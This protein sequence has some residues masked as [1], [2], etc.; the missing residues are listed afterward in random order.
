MMFH[1]GTLFLL[2]FVSYCITTLS[3][4]KVRIQE[5]RMK[6]VRVV[7]NSNIELTEPETAR[8]CLRL[9]NRG[10]LQRLKGRKLFIRIESILLG[11][12]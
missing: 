4:T 9:L 8:G 1:D 5:N 10:V 11:M 12:L 6:F 7:D 2:L 3:T